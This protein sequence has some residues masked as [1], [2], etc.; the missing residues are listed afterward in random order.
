[1]KLLGRETIL[2]LE[3]GFLTHTVQ[4]KLILY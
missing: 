3:W 2:S 4:M 1:M